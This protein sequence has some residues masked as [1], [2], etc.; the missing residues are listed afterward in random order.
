M[1]FLILDAAHLTQKNATQFHLDHSQF[2]TYYTYR[3]SYIY[4]EAFSTAQTFDRVP[5]PSFSFLDFS[6]KESDISK[7]TCSYANGFPKCN[8]TLLSLTI[9]LSD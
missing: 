3:S 8:N 9:A 6:N 7:R 1:Y 5:A 2:G 4:I